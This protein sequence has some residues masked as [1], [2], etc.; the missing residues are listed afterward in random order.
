MPKPDIWIGPTRYRARVV[1]GGRLLTIGEGNV[2]GA[3]HLDDGLI[4][5]AGDTLQR[6]RDAALHEVLHA[7]LN[8]ANL[9]RCIKPDEL[10]NLVL[11]LARELTHC[12]ER[13]RWRHKGKELLPRYGGGK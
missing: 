11:G 7:V 10:E 8:D 9:E 13:S 2:N 5:V 12:F 1:K 3:A 4:V 6:M